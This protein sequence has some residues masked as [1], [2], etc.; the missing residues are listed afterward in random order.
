MAHYD[1]VLF[2]AGE[3]RQRT[4]ELGILHYAQIGLNA[5][6]EQH[7]SLGAAG[8]E[9]TENAVAR[10]EGLDDVRAVLC[11]HEKINVAAHLFAAPQTA[12][13]VAADHVRVTAQI[14]KDRFGGN[15][16]LVPVMMASVLALERDAL[17]NFLLTLF[18]KPIQL[19]HLARFT[20]S[21]QRLDGFDAEL[22]VEG[23]DLLGAHALNIQHLDQP[24]RD[25]GFEV[26]V[27]LQFAGLDQFC[28][29]LNQRLADAFHFAESFFLDERF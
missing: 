14:L 11:G 21:F 27:V 26:G 18:A 29:F 7:A 1:V 8:G 24:S 4:G 15:Q 17:E 12:G 13:D 25:G 19:G 23:L 6:L 9:Y 28:Y 10:G 22:V 3:I 5:A 2:A 20:G 16:H